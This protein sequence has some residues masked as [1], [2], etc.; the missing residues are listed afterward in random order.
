MQQMKK[1]NIAHHTAEPI[2]HQQNPTEG[3][4]REVRRKWYCVMVHKQVPPGLW[5]MA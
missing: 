2:L 1:D 4:I 5:D 3:V